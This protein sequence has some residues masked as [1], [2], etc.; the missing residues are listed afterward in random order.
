MDVISNIIR[1]CNIGKKDGQIY[2]CGHDDEYICGSDFVNMLCA[3]KVDELFQERLPISRPI[4]SITSSL[5]LQ[6]LGQEFENRI[7][8]I[9]RIAG[10]LSSPKL[11]IVDI[12]P[13]LAQ[14]LREK[15]SKQSNFF[16]REVLYFYS[17]YDDGNN[18][19]KLLLVEPIPFWEELDEELLQNVSENAQLLWRSVIPLYGRPFFIQEI[20]E[21]A[22]KLN[23]ANVD[24]CIK[25]LCKEQL[26]FQEYAYSSKYFTS[27]RLDSSPPTLKNAHSILLRLFDKSRVICYWCVWAFASQMKDGDEIS[28]RQVQTFIQSFVEKNDWNYEE[29][30]FMVKERVF[31]CI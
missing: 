26:L 12:D 10:S 11:S 8:K 29:E 3:R 25:E 6:I 31:Y 7:F 28:I 30:F 24:S 1:R 5:R 2:F 27:R 9:D 14:S 23:I 4:F 18:N 19:P 16:Q 22:A 17:Q 13:D 21:P 20:N 15:F